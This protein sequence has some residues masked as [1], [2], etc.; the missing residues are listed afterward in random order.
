MDIKYLKNGL[1][2]MDR[3]AL[4]IWGLRDAFFNIAFVLRL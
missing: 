4:G 3:L 1:I 2:R